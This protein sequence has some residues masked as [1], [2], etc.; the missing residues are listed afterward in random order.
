MWAVNASIKFGYK[1]KIGNGN[2]VRF[3]GFSIDI[4][5]VM[6]KGKIVNQI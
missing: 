5:Y 6:N 4:S 1:W 2:S 3:W